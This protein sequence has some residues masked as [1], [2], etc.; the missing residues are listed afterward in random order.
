MTTAVDQ[1]KLNKFMKA[2]WSYLSI[3]ELSKRSVSLPKEDGVVSHGTAGQ[4]AVSDGNG[5]IVWKTL[6][7]AEGVS[8]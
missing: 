4:F 2:G 8:Y 6:V 1:A 7:E 3:G 5:G